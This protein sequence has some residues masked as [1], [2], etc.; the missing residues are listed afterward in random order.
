MRT[1]IPALD[2]S[3]LPLQELEAQHSYYVKFMHWISDA[4]DCKIRQ[5]LLL[6]I[7]L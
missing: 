4:L 3:G 2:A 5:K 1:N 6:K 7:L